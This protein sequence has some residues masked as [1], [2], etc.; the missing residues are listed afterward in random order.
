MRAALLALALLPGAAAGQTTIRQEAAPTFSSGAASGVVAYAGVGQLVGINAVNGTTA[1]YAV[2]YDAVAVPADGALTPSLV[3]WCM[4]LAASTGIYT[5]FT[6]PLPF[7]NGVTFFVT[8]GGC[9]SKTAVAY[10]YVGAQ[11]RQ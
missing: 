1:G 8:S 3:R 7:Y 10:G 2:L 6:A 11:V 4:P 9:T 5:P